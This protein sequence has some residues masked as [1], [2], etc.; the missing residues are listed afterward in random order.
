MSKSAATLFVFPSNQSIQIKS[1]GSNIS[2]LD[3]GALLEVPL[4]TD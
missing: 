2:I 3:A 4:E 1:V